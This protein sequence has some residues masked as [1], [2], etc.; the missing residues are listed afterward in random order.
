MLSMSR[1]IQNADDVSDGKPCAVP[2]CAKEAKWKG[3]C[4]TCYG[5]A[6]SMIDNGETTWEELERMGLALI[7][8]NKLRQE[9]YR[10]KE[11]C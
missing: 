8:K 2:E 9:F 4:Q 5:C 6:K 1:E 3:L 7:P 10:R 11:G